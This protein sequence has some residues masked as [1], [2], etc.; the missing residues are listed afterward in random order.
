MWQ[1]DLIKAGIFS[2]GNNVDIFR[3][4]LSISGGMLDYNPSGGKDYY[5][6]GNDGQAGRT[7]FGWDNSLDTLA[8]AISLSHAWIASVARGWAARNRIFIK[9]DRL[10]ETL[11]SFPQKT[12]IIGVGSCDNFTRVVLRGNHAPT[13]AAVGTRWFNVQFEPTSA[14]VIMTLTNASTG[15]EFHN[16]IFEAWGA[17]TAV[18]AIKT[19]AHTWLK[20]IGCEFNGAYSDTVIDIAAGQINGMV[21]RGNTIQGG[22][23]NG[24]EV[25]GT[26]TVTRSK[27]GLIADNYI[28]VAGFVILDGNDNTLNVMCNRGISAGISEAAAFEIDEGHAVDNVITYNDTTSVRVPIIPSA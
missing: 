21:I 16:C 26:T 25:T 28:Q 14:A 8:E 9:G 10:V 7:G 19:T 20:V 5:V 11:T 27:L 17:A 6:D 3:G 13:N 22:A 15:M 24:I 4:N 12:D 2:D 1:G 23:Q 18:S